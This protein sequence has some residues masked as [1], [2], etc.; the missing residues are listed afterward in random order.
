VEDATA[1]R[2]AVEATTGEAPTGF[3]ATAV[4]YADST[5]EAVTTVIAV[6]AAEA[7]AA[8]IAIAPAE[9]GTGT[10]EDAADEVVRSIVAIRRT[11]I[12]V[13]AIVAIRTN[14]CGVRITIRVGNTY[15]DSDRDLGVGRRGDTKGDQEDTEQGE[16]AKNFHDDSPSERA[17]RLWA[18][19]DR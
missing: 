8:T 10:D 6:T 9:P 11:G 7:V 19:V 5:P 17:V 14:R 1:D 15:A 12:R 13:V 3:D 16:I 2:T 18:A 4:T